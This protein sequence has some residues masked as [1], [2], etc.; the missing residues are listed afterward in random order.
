MT[1]IDLL[2]A[3][4]LLW[5]IAGIAW[6]IFY[7]FNPQYKADA[8]CWPIITFVVSFIALWCY[9]DVR[10]DNDVR[11]QQVYDEFHEI[12]RH[13]PELDQWSYSVVDNHVNQV[14]FSEPDG[15]RCQGEVD[16]TELF[17]V[18]CREPYESEKDNE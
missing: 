12:V 7:R 5:P 2:H 10:H 1:H 3:T 9:A 13:Y 15:D 4:W 14:F 17:N 11:D 16:R 6:L 8:L 18:N